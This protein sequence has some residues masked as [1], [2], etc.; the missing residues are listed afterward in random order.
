MVSPSAM[1]ENSTLHTSHST[2][3]GVLM[4]TDF[5]IKAERFWHKSR[6]YSRRNTLCIS[7]LEI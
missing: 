2:L 3:K 7:R 6:I 4:E 1:I 5:Q